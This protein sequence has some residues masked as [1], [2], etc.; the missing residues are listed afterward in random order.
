[1]TSLKPFSK[2]E[3]AD[4]LK[5]LANN[6]FTD[7]DEANHIALPLLN[8]FALIEL[9]DKA[10]KNSKKSNTHPWA[11]PL[12][13]L[14]RQSELAIKAKYAAS[15]KL[16]RKETDSKIQQQQANYY[17]TING[18][19]A[20]YNYLSRKQS[21]VDESFN[22]LSGDYFKTKYLIQKSRE[23]VKDKA[24]LN[25]A[26]SAEL[27]SAFSFAFRLSKIEYEAAKIMY[28]AHTFKVPNLAKIASK[29][30]SKVE[31]YPYSKF[32]DELNTL[33][34]D[35]K[36]KTFFKYNLPF[37]DNPNHIL[38]L[39]TGKKLNSYPKI[40]FLTIYVTVRQTDNIFNTVDEEL[41]KMLDTA[42]GNNK[43][44]N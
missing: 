10:T 24:Q 33:G 28:I 17:Q 2:Q 27:S 34:K 19:L 26:V 13:A 44:G 29:W 18:G 42:L 35:N 43:R 20:F 22:A 14:D 30:Y 37:S 11:R 16:I 3:A 7:I 41:D 25:K 6:D 23:S 32:S 21:R 9:S 12:N 40:D 8:L 38:S 1:M 36:S 31:E 4:Y 15:I 39:P 5:N